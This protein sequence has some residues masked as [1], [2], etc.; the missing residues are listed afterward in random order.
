MTG[1]AVIIGAGQAGLTA[2]TALREQGWEGE[3]HLI[4]EEEHLPYQ[5]PPLSKGYLAGYENRETLLLR[6]RTAIE[7]DGVMLHL[8]TRVAA[9]NRAERSVELEGSRALP[10]EVLIIATGSAP[11][12]LGIP[13]S[14][15]EGVHAVRTIEDADRLRDD[16]A[17]GGRTV[18]IGAGFLNLEV[19]VEALKHGEVSVLE[20][21]PQ[22]LGRVLSR[23]TANALQQYH[24]DLGIEIRCD[25]AITALRGGGGRV[26]GIELASGEVVPAERVVLSIGAIARDELAA[27][28]GLETHGGIVVDSALRTS[29]DRIFAIGD[30][31]KYPSPWAGMR[32][33][34]ESVQNATDQARHLAETLVA[35]RDDPYRAV[36]WFWSVQGERRLQIAGIAMPDDEARLVEQGEAGRLV[37]ERLRGGEVVAVESVNAPAAHMKARRELGAL[38]V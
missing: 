13:G 25:A 8:G 34:V 16:L 18:F 12:L 30:C 19:A 1:N 35:G 29:D 4:G 28:A 23:E 15:L 20:V 9:I 17:R 33:R 5:R 11:R 37:V 10:Y 26:I 6:S 32:M 7:Q 38:L 36:P 3:I 14:D 2:A 24:S 27:A 22:I 21:A 31:A